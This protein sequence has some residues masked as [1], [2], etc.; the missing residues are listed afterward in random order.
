MNKKKAFA[1]TAMTLA[2]LGFI[3]AEE[4]SSAL[5]ADAEA[6]PESTATAAEAAPTPATSSS[7]GAFS[8]KLSGDHEFS[9][10]VPAYTSDGNGDYSGNMKRPTF[11]NDIGAEIK[12][13]PVKLVSRWGLDLS[14]VSSSGSGSYAPASSWEGSL[15]IRPYENYVSWSPEGFKAS[16]G[17]QIFSWGVADKRNPTDNLNPRDWTTGT[18]PAK[19][20]VLAGDLTWYPSES[21]SLEGVFL[22]SKPDSLYPRDFAQIVEA[23]SGLSSVSYGYDAADPKNFVAGGKLS[24]RSP[25]LDLSLDYLYDLDQYYTPKLSFGAGGSLDSISL[26]RRRIHR[27]GGDAKTTLGKFGLWLEAAYNVT[28]NSGSD[29]Y[30]VRRS[31]LEYTLGTDV[32]FGPNDVG[33]INLQYIG[34]WIPGYKKDAPTPYTAQYYEWM[35]VD[36]LGLDTEGLMQGFTCNVKYEIADAFLTPQATV[37][38]MMPFDYDDS[39]YNRYG[40]LVLSPEIDIMPMDSFHI[41]LGADLCYAWRQARGSDAIVLDTENDAVGS[42]TPSNNVYLKILYKWNYELKK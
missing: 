36:P 8:L 2:V 28:E 42:Y 24:Y 34:T 4:D 12:D 3:G 21:L 17:Y 7:E 18:D 30:S 41:K 31:K 16:A 10:H 22:P 39:L 9:Y 35:M 20:P 26:E 6:T 27:I 14:P 32:N 19:I 37:A 38:Y 29:D 11:R 15:R 5:F 1:A 25:G 13:G 40:S 33:Y 23:Q